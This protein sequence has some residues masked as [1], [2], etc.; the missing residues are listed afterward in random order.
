MEMRVGQ[1]AERAGVSVDT[2]RYYQARGLLEPPRRSGRDAWYGAAHLERIAQVR[3]LRARGI[4]LAAIARMTSGELDDA[5]KAL[6]GALAL[7]TLPEGS[8]ELIDVE[9]LALRTGVAVPIL[10]ALAAEGFLVPRRIGTKEG[11]TPEDVELARAGFRLLGW[12]LPLPELLELARAHDHATRDFAERAVALFD[13][14]VRKGTRVNA[15]GP[16]AS[17]N[18]VTAFEEILPATIAL[19][20]HHFTRVLLETAMT[21]MEHVG[22]P[23]ELEA[24]R[25]AAAGEPAGGGLARDTSAS[26]RRAGE[27]ARQR[28]GQ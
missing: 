12:G 25:R 5:D 18:L 7:R 22:S 4:T 28:S 24:V 13:E 20:T 1:L 17:V 2:V 8:G 9:E 23:D 6:A 3:A 16:E 15:A 27:L 19:V 14:Y 11:Y 21:H 26:Q 10:E